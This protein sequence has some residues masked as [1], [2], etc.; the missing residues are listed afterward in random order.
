ME[1]ED[2]F[3]IIA[4]AGA[5]L[6]LMQGAKDQVSDAYF[7]VNSIYARA[8]AKAA[9][10]GAGR[11]EAVVDC[12]RALD[13]E[14]L[15]RLGMAQT[16]TNRGVIRLANNDPRGALNDF[17]AAID[18]DP[19]LA[20]AYINRAAMLLTRGELDRAYSDADRAVQL[21]NS[22]ARAWLIRGGANEMRG[23][24]AEAYKD[25]QMA[26]KLDPA[27]DRPKEELARF[28]VGR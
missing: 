24:A 28:K 26:A 16:L 7:E 21:N 20:A 8:C 3:M 22:S 6:L 12:T 14:P 18:Q 11:M 17:N 9:A 4:I 27:W 13:S 23:K 5:A 10:N 2:S 1:G 25:Y 15:N 19:T